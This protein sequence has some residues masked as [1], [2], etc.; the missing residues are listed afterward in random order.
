MRRYLTVAVGVGAAMGLAS[1][2]CQNTP[3]NESQ[4]ATL[5]GE[6]S[7]AVE[8][9]LNEDPSLRSMLDRSVG[10]AI[11]PDVG[12][13]GLIAGGA[14]GRGEVYERGRMIGYATLTQGTVGLQVGAQ[15]YDE[16]IVFTTQQALDRFK[17]GEFAFSGNVSAVAIKPG[18]AAGTTARDGVA[19]FV[20]TKGGLMA[21]ASVGGQQFS[22]TAR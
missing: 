2:G 16:L 1:L 6:S 10:Y 17:S 5:S 13:A 18:A 15:T 11:F 3:K 8:A 9:F 22:F 21:E 14:H 20:R 19:V 12:K 4:R 7:A